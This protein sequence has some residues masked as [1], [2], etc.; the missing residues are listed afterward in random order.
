M[1]RGFNIFL[2]LIFSVLLIINPLNLSTAITFKDTIITINSDFKSSFLSIDVTSLIDRFG[3]EFLKTEIAKDFIQKEI[4]RNL[5]HFDGI[6]DGP[7]VVL[8]NKGRL[9]TFNNN[10]KK[11]S[12]NQAPEGHI[13]FDYDNAIGFDGDELEYIKN[14]IEGGGPFTFGMRNCIERVFGK[15]FFDLIIKLEMLDT[16]TSSYNMSTQTITLQ[17]KISKVND[18]YP[19]LE[20]LTHEIIHACSDILSKPANCFDEGMVV[21][22]TNLA[23]KLFCDYNGVMGTTSRIFDGTTSGVKSYDL[24]NQPSMTAQNGFFWTTSSIKRIIESSLRYSMSASAW[25]KVWRET[26]PENISALNYRTYGSDTFFV[27]FNR[28]YF[29]TFK[30][31]IESGRPVVYDVQTLTLVKALIADTLSKDVDKGGQ[32]T[33][34]G[35]PFLAWFNNQF[36]LGMK[37]EMGTKLFISP[38][39]SVANTPT[40]ETIIKG[41][42]MS[43]TAQFFDVDTKG[44][45]IELFGNMTMLVKSLHETS[46]LNF[47]EDV[48]CNVRYSISNVVLPTNWVALVN[49]DDVIATFNKGKI[50]GALDFSSLPKGAY[51]IDFIAMTF[52]GFKVA[53]QTIFFSN[54]LDL[55]QSNICF[56]AIAYRNKPFDSLTIKKSS[57]SESV[58]TMVLE[59][60]GTY[61]FSFNKADIITFT[62]MRLDENFNPIVRTWMCNAGSQLLVKNLR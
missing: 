3:I 19:K 22:Q 33:V 4:N 47:S 25:F 46:D 30:P 20:T 12:Q 2:V 36:I 53:T 50:K 51:Q 24:D 40:K 27:D 23:C 29:E 15:P 44:N 1:S 31:W 38:S 58:E 16:A 7:M 55:S 62:H 26:V 5:D 6:S 43:F 42:V 57:A 49:P 56:G 60:D 34:E 48:T 45:E 8:T 32:S 61:S 14:F 11:M 39:Y 54:K 37:P 21:V 13:T 17:P 59:G 28:R 9:V 10:L 35:E 18:L 41:Q 52:D